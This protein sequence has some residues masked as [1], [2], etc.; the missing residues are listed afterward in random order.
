MMKK[1]ALKLVIRRETVRLLARMD[2]AQIAA[3]ENALVGTGTAGT[4]CPFQRQLADSA[5]GETGC[6]YVRLIDSEDINRT[7]VA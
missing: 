5:G 4:G 7:C 3:G 2:L 6:P 1:E